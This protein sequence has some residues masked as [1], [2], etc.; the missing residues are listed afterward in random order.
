MAAAREAA[1]RSGIE[2]MREQARK[3][4]ERMTF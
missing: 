3:R 1:A 4:G 2:W